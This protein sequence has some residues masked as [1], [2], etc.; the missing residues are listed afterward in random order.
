L[1][2]PWDIEETGYEAY[3]KISLG[4]RIVGN[5]FPKV[6]NWN[7]MAVRLLVRPIAEAQKRSGETEALLRRE[8]E[9]FLGWDRHVG[10][11]GL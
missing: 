4:E 8:G 7:Y 1:S 5:G 2:V 6:I 3:E 9:D 10:N 11:E